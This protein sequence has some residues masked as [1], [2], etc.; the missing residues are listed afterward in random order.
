MKRVAVTILLLYFVALYAVGLT[1]SDCH[2]IQGNSALLSLNSEGL[3]ASGLLY[4]TECLLPDN[5]TASE[6]PT[7]DGEDN[8]S[9]MPSPA[10]DTLE[11]KVPVS[12]TAEFAGTESSGYRTLDEIPA[13]KVE[14][15]LKYKQGMLFTSDNE[16]LSIENAGMYFSPDDIRKIQR[17][18][19]RF[20]RGRSIVDFGLDA[21]GIAAGSG[22]IIGV[23][24]QSD[25]VSVTA[26]SVVIAVVCIVPCSIIGV[27]M[28]LSGKAGMKRLVRI[29]NNDYICED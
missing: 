3:A 17:C 2:A 6:M 7:S 19:K 9:H 8:L 4:K 26:I 5:G 1:A 11:L 27:P 16:R 22:L 29:Y 28:M 20:S 14:G 18:M 25:M 12:D 15:T 21:G 10:V 24:S 13:V 23:E